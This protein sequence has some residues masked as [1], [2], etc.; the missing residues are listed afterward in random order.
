MLYTRL[1]GTGLQ[2]SRITL[3]CMSWGD[4]E[5]GGHPWVKDAG[6]ADETVAAALAE[7]AATDAI[8]V[9]GVRAPTLRRVTIA[10]TGMRTGWVK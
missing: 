1:G 5:R 2:V 4:P 6:F 10:A 9:E 3:G 8:R 7:L